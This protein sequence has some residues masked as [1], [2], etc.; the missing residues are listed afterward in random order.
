MTAAMT[1]TSSQPTMLSNIGR[2]YVGVT[3]YMSRASAA[4]DRADIRR[5]IDSPRRS[6]GI[7][8]VPMPYTLARMTAVSDAV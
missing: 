1:T 2:K 8:V 7:R 5:A 6:F 4:G 3:K